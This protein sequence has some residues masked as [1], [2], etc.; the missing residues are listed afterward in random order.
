MRRTNYEAPQIERLGT[1]AELTEAAGNINSD[2]HM[3]A[4]NAFSN[5]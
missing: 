4:N 2:N 1:V 5:P 3:T